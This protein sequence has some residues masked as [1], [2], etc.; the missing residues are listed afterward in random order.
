MVSA[1]KNNALRMGASAEHIRRAVGERSRRNK[2]RAGRRRRRT[3]SG[4][5]AVNDEQRERSEKDMA[6][7]GAADVDGSTSPSLRE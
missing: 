4:G 7:M 2:S 5:G 3:T 6:W 1:T